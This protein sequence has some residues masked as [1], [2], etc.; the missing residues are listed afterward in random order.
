MD[1][2]N[3]GLLLTRVGLVARASARLARRLALHAL[4]LAHLA[5]GAGSGARVAGV[6]TGGAVRASME[7]P[8][9]TIRVQA[10]GQSTVNTTD[11]RAS[12]GG[13]SKHEKESAKRSREAV[14]RSLRTWTLRTGRQGT[15]CSCWRPPR[16]TRRR[17]CRTHEAQR[18]EREQAWGSV[19]LDAC[20]LTSRSSCCDSRLRACLRRCA[21]TAN[22]T[23]QEMLTRD[24]AE[25]QARRVAHHSEHCWALPVETW[26]GRQRVQAVALPT[27]AK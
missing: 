2:R 19:G 16:K 21:A 24:G 25:E 23:Q 6:G 10:D 17:R 4:R 22:R 8:H 26:P 15:A 12:D 7:E 13:N 5:R 20:E 9:H 27:A 1:G 11:T 3:E 14:T 18:H